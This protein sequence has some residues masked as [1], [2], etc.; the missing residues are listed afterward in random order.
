MAETEPST[1]DGLIRVL[2]A[3]STRIGSQLMLEAL[4]RDDRLDVVALLTAA[5][6]FIPTISD[7]KP[8]VLVIGAAGHS[9]IRIAF[10]LLWRTLGRFPKSRA[11][12]ILE[13]STEELVVE[14]FRAGARGVLSWDDGVDALRKCVHV[15]HLGQIWASSAQLG[16]VLEVFSRRWVPQTVVDSSGRTLLSKRELDVVRCVSEGLTNREIAVKLDLS[17][18]TIKNYLFRTFN[19]LGIS[20]RSELI[21]YALNHSC[22]SRPGETDRGRARTENSGNGGGKIRAEL[23][24]GNSRDVRNIEYESGAFNRT[25]AVDGPRES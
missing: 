1:A 8:H 11:V 13:A 10:D 12:M 16:S 5:D 20:N 21:L 6:E 4:R 17:E 19:K 22:S 23:A 14:A 18:H 25:N 9:N 24:S 3:D 7:F 2:V 15:V